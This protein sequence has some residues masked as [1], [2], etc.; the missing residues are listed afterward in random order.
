MLQSYEKQTSSFDTS[1]H[2][3]M[4]DVIKQTSARIAKARHFFDEVQGCSDL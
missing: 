2:S 4:K 1:E 3:A